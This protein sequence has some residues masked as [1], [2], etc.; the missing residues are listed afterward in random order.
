[1]YHEY[2]F[3]FFICFNGDLME[4]IYPFFISFIMIFISELGD[5]TQL[6]VLSF[7]N[8]LRTSRILLGIALGTFFSHGF[9]ILFGSKLSSISSDFSVYLSIFTYFSFILF[10]V[11]GFVSS[12]NDNNK[13]NVNKNS[14][15]Y[16]VSNFKISYVLIIA[17]S[18]FIG[19]LGDKTFL[20]S[21][22]LGI[23]YSNFQISLILGSIFGMICSNSIAIFFGKFIANKFNP[24]VI[25]VFSNLLFI[26]FGILGFL[27]FFVSN[28]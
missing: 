5:K 12:R 14:I 22:G 17:I 24:E 21:L 26:I 27:N 15:L 11:L 4:F 23:Q 18:I 2:F 28:S 6:L 10:G 1:M 19:E 8:K 7:S 16:R 20:A 9:A 13:S 3:I 25:D